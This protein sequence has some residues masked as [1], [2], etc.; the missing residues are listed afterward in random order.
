MW[1]PS[2]GLVRAVVP[3]SQC[4]CVSARRKEGDNANSYHE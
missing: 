3:L 4:V 1:A 2:R